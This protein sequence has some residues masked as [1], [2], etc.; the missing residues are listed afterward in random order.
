MWSSAAAVLHLMTLLVYMQITEQRVLK[1]K[2]GFLSKYVKH[3]CIVE[4]ESTDQLQCRNS[5]RQNYS[6]HFHVVYI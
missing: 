2:T 1:C 4:T 6:P 5:G 3:L